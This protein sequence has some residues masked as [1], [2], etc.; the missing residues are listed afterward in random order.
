MYSG[1]IRERVTEA[2]FCGVA[3]RDEQNEGDK[4]DSA[5]ASRES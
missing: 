4:C 2:M 1:V 5:R 3:R